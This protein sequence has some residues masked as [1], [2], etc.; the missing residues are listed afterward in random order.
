MNQPATQN[1][2]RRFLRSRPK[3]NTWV[4]DNNKH[5]G[6]KLYRFEDTLYMAMM[7]FNRDSNSNFPQW[8]D[9]KSRMLGET[10]QTEN[11]VF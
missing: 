9:F 10:T 11:E 6:N 5:D 3:F 4:L 1:T 8:A 7:K 2:H